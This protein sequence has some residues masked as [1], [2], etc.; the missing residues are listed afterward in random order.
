LIAEITVSGAAENDMK[1]LTSIVAVNQQGAIGCKNELPWRLRTDMKF[2]REQTIDNVVIMGR[3]TYESVN[4]CLPQ[5]TNIVL[6]HNAVL[7]QSTENCAVSCS[8]E[9]CLVAAS[10]HPKKQV[11]VMGGASTY[12]QFAPFVDRYLITV[13]DKRVDDADAFLSE[14]IFGDV[15]GW[16][17]ATI[18]EYPASEG[19]DEAPFKIF[20]WNAHDSERRAELRAQVIADFRQ[21]ALLTKKGSKRRAGT[22]SMPLWASP[23]EL[24]L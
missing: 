8:I 23:L 18:A 16:D 9:E 15:D 12:A 2:F 20:E 10:K 11:F 7:F 22:P 21:R 13:V 19:I 6:S 3:K 5:R 4:G 17:R 14:E 1:S 24:Q